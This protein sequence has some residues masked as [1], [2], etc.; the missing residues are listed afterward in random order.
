MNTA[1]AGPDQPH[2]GAHHL[3]LGR[4]GRAHGLLLHHQQG[5]LGC[6]LVLLLNASLKVG[7]SAEEVL[8]VVAACKECDS[9]RLSFAT[10]TAG[11]AS[12][13]TIGAGGQNRPSGQR[14]T[15]TARR[16]RK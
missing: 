6:L 16:T 9:S 1:G 15:A 13:F 2:G 11:A 12:A 8:R 14:R 5:E 7:G 3:H 4:G 10:A